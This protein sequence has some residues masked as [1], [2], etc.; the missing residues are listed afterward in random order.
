MRYLTLTEEKQQY[1]VAILIPQIRKDEIVNS[2]ITPY[3]LDPEDVIVIATH[4]MPGAKKTPA[5]EMKAW[6]EQELAPTLADLGTTHLIVADGDYFKTLIGETK[7]EAFLGYVKP[8]KIPSVHAVYVPNHKAIFYDP[9]KTVAKI[10]QGITALQSHRAGAYVDPGQ[11]IIKFEAYPTDPKV[12][13]KWL[14]KFIDEGT[15]LTADIEAFS[16]KHHTAG[17]GTISFAWNKHEGIAFAVDFSEHSELIRAMLREFFIQHQAK[18]TWHGIS[19]DVYVLIYQLFMKDILDT[20]GLLFGLSVMLKNWDCTKLITYLATNSCAGNKLGLKPNSQEYSGNYAVEEIEDIRKIP[21]PKLLR[22]NLVDSL[23][24]WYVKEK[25]EPTMD[26]DDQ[27]N[28][29]ETLFKP[30][31][32]DI[33]QM[34]L[35]GMPVDMERVKIARGKLEADQTKAIATLRQSQLVQQYTHILNEKW[36]TKR[37]EKLKVKRVTIEE[38]KEIF[39]PNSGDQVRELL[40]EMVG[41]PVIS[42]TKNKQASTDGDTLKDLRNHT[43]DPQVLEFLNAMLDY[44]AVNKILTSFIP[45][46]EAAAPGPDGW[47]YLFGN[48]NLGGTLSGRLSSSEPNLQNLPA[49]GSKY[50]KIIKWCFRAPPGWLFAGLDFNSL[51][52]RISA[53]TTKDPNK[54]KVYTDGYDGHCLRAYAY[55]GDKMPDIDPNSVV[56]INSIAKKYKDDRQESKVP[57]FALTYMG[58]Y[59]TLMKNCGFSKEKA[60]LIEERYH[61]LYKVSDDWVAAKIDQ[62]TKDGYVTV[63]FGLRVRTPLLAQ[64]IRGNSKTPYEAEAEGRSAGNAL[65]QSYCLLNS[66]AGNEFMQTVRKSDYRLDI[67]PCAQIHDAQYFLIRDD[68]KIISYSNTHL[69]KAVKWQEDPLIQHDEVKLG[70]ELSIFWP[71]WSKEATIPNDATEQEI[72]AVIDA[73]IAEVTSQ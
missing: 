64:V 60:Q 24:T 35:T 28:V 41:L 10:A 25:H 71:D 65:G 31:M 48:F 4:Q 11:S 5:K 37:N 34:Q 3:G 46:M 2:Y 22:Y 66:R 69:V 43:K 7:A 42:L 54:L 52:D 38:A 59:I 63:A 51:E 33:I 72:F 50:A 62:A 6:I 16:L 15:E 20:E 8:T 40:Y 53:L 56:S 61:V 1:P 49:T 23:S 13:E 70:G 21:L 47:H 55:F 73:H 39:N 27:R 17:I 9:E 12:I 26:R 58:T 45:A 68:I 57:T 14:V 30:C 32:W 44:N 67:R 36:V 19:Y 29:Y 18:I